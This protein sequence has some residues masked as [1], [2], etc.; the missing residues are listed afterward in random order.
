MVDAAEATGRGPD[1]RSAGSVEVAGRSAPLFAVDAVSSAA[2]SAAF[3]TVNPVCEASANPRG[4]G[5]PAAVSGGGGV[6]FP[7]FPRETRDFEP[8]ALT[9]AGVE[10]L[11]L[12]VVAAG[13][14]GILAISAEYGACAPLPQ[15]GVNR[16]KIP[17]PP[18][19]D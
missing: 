11:E 19:P 8:A 3:S 9:L 2:F 12:D 14:F 13:G 5:V 16:G 7:D 17:T 6:G 18:I 15:D 10:D 1:W 4:I